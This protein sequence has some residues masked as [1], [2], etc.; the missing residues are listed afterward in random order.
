MTSQTCLG[1]FGISKTTNNRVR[2]SN[3]L[4]LPKVLSTSQASSEPGV[5]WAEKHFGKQAGQG[6]AG[7]AL[8]L[9]EGCTTKAEILP[10]H[11]I[12]GSQ[13]F[14]L[15]SVENTYLTQCELDLWVPHFAKLSVQQDQ[16]FQPALPHFR[17]PR[18]HP[19][20]PA[21]GPG[22]PSQQLPW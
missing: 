8:R 15:T 10:Q 14:V 20:L 18:P 17:P 21:L 7:S 3:L 11:R 19:Q 1:L 16:I 13:M 5:H 22:Q 12:Y 4:G 6:R 9:Q 2:N